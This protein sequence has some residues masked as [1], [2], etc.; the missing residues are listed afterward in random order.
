MSCVLPG[1]TSQGATFELRYGSREVDCS[2]WGRFKISGELC[3]AAPIE[4][5]G[6]AAAVEGL[7]RFIRARNEECKVPAVTA[8]N[9]RVLAAD[10]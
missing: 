8:D 4:L 2:A 6:D 9:R 10:G 3:H 5:A 7:R 1:F